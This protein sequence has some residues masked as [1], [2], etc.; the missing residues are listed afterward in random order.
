MKAIPIETIKHIKII[1]NSL[2]VHEINIR[3]RDNYSV[4]N[5]VEASASDVINIIKIST[6]KT[7]LIFHK[8]L[9]RCFPSEEEH[10]DDDSGHEVK[11]G[12]PGGIPIVQFTENRRS[13]GGNQV[14]Y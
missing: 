10:H 5:G 13:E 8:P 2:I 7:I 11:G 9:L 3:L 6:N 1:F 14:A 12:L 4:S